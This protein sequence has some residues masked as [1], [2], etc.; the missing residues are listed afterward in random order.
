MYKRQD[1]DYGFQLEKP[2]AGDTIAVMHTSMGDISLRLFPEAAPKAV[3]N[4][5]THAKEGYY[6]GLIFHR[7]MD[8][9]MIQGG[10]PK[11][12]GTGGESIWGEPFE[13]EFYQKLLNLRAVSYT[14]LDVYKRQV[15]I[16]RLDVK[17]VERVEDVVNVGDEVMVKVTEIDEQGRLNLS[18][19]D[20]LI[21]VEGLT[22]ENT[23]SDA[24]RREG[25]RPMRR[26]GG[27]DNGRPRRPE[28]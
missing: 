25:G 19:R 15:H 24:P 9:F 28:R 13:D 26:E 8:D 17:R 2:T 4:F 12:N 3:E 10:D 27:R 5:T 16:S 1:K 7:V 23:S 14:H 21:E 22:P 18:R 11:G 6:N 20:A